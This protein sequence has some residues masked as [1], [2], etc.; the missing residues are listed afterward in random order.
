MRRLWAVAR[1]TFQEG[2][3][4][5]LTVVL[6]GVMVA[7]IVLIPL[8]YGGITT[9]QSVLDGTAPME[10]PA[11]QVKTVLDYA[12][13]LIAITLSVLTVLLTCWIICHDVERRSVFTTLAKP[14]AR[15]QYILGRWAGVCLIQAMLIGLAGLALYGTVHYMRY[16]YDR[17]VGLLE[18]DLPAKLVN[19]S[20]ARAPADRARLNGMLAD[21][22]HSDPAAWA[23]Y[24]RWKPVREKLDRLDRNVL[25]ARVRCRPSDTGKRLAEAQAERKRKLTESG[26]YAS[27]VLQFGEDEVAQRI[28]NYAVGT[29]ES[30]EDGQTLSWRFTDLPKPGELVGGDSVQFRIKLSAVNAIQLEDLQR[31]I[32]VYNPTTGDEVPLRMLVPVGAPAWVDIPASMITPD[33]TLQ[34]TFVNEPPQDTIVEGIHSDV[35]IPLSEVFLLYRVGNFASNFLRG[36]LLMWVFQAF[37]AAVAVL[38]ASWLSFPIACLWCAVLYLMGTMGPFFATDAMARAE[39]TVTN[40]SEWLLRGVVA[41]MPNFTRTDP[42]P[43][44]VA[45]VEIPWAHV[46]TTIGIFGVLWGGVALAI[47]AIIFTRRELARVVA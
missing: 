25:S 3:R 21:L 33:G 13:G 8:L 28:R 16:P 11:D 19:A 41:V 30:A 9:V 26:D 44:L 36:L 35:H 23:A 43:P 32:E 14:L 4:S 46:A 31:D 37:L 38:A 6:I 7:V 20:F 34:I 45:G 10:E 17:A 5:R 2:T 1:H 15:W 22:R 39:G 24:H 40:L 42:V 29:L 27:Q 18:K 12:I 47:G